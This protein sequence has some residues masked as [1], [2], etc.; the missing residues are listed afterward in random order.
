MKVDRQTTTD[1]APASG[2][3]ATNPEL[4]RQAVEYERFAYIL[5]GCGIQFNRS[6]RVATCF[7]H[8]VSSSPAPA[9]YISK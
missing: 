5:A 1:N 3:V 9:G 7:V 6:T 8:N 4:T 2:S